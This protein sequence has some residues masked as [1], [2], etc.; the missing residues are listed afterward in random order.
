MQQSMGSNTARYM[1]HFRCCEIRRVVHM[2]ISSSRRRLP[3]P[4]SP[5]AIVLIGVLPVCLQTWQKS[6]TLFAKAV[7]SALQKEKSLRQDLAVLTT[8][9]KEK[10]SANDGPLPLPT[11]RL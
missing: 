7:L 6:R 9:I 1:A 2:G 10:A 11:A 8:V 5:F 4:P 3:L